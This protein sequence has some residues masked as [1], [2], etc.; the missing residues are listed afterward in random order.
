VV[1]DFANYYALVRPGGV[2]VFDDYG[3]NIYS[4]EV[5]RAVDDIVRLHPELMVI[6]VLPNQAGSFG[7]NVPQLVTSSN[8]FIVQKPYLPSPTTFGIC[9]ATYNHGR[10]SAVKA[11]LSSLAA[12]TFTDWTLFIVG[13]KHTDEQAL[14]QLLPT[15]KVVLVN[16]PIA[17]ERD[18]TSHKH[19]LYT[20]GGATAMNY[21]AELIKHA[22][23]PYIAHLDDDDVW[24]PNHLAVINAQFQRDADLSFVFTR[25]VHFDG[26]VI[27]SSNSSIPLPSDVLHSAISW[28]PAKLTIVLPYDSILPADSLVLEEVG[29]KCRAGTHKS[30]LCPEVTVTHI[31][32][33]VHR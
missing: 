16:L 22:R 15:E 17:C 30:C 25:G 33:A 29:K 4:P 20:S 7:N 2:I 12:Q 13:D 26:R 14:R 10:M 21:A 27:P 6:G 3:D 5:S 24:A 32:E 18:F 23:C 8:E 19:L 31:D 28:N 9:M 1:A 11:M